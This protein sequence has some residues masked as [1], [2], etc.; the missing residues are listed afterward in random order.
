MSLDSTEDGALYL[1]K[2][3][4]YVEAQSNRLK[5]LIQQKMISGSKIGE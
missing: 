3:Q 5:K 2:T 1:L 4:E